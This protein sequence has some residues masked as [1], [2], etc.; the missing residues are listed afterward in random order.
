MA[1]TQRR[2]RIKIVSPLEGMVGKSLDGF[3][4]QIYTEVYRVNDDGVKS[5]VFGY[6]KDEDLANAFIAGKPDPA[7]H[8]TA[9]VFL[10]TDGKV[11]FLVGEVAH[12]MDE[13]CTRTE[14]RE[15]AARK[16]TKEE[17]K[18]LGI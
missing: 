13:E 12:I 6:L 8:K 9:Q 16:L 18:I 5:N 17:R 15:S 10:L 11:G 2:V 14:V 4:V 7:W 1:D 3:T